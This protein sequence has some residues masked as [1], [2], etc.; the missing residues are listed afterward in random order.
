MADYYPLIARAVTGLDK[1]T[2][3]ARRALYE[4]ARTALVTQLRGVEPALS[5]ADITRERLAL[6]EAIRKVEAEAARRPQQDSAEVPAKV[7]TPPPRFEQPPSSTPSSPPPPPPSEGRSD[8]AFAPPP[9]PDWDELHRE[10]DGNASPQAESVET[11][12]AEAE[13]PEAAPEAPSADEPPLPLETE[14]QPEP[15]PTESASP[16]EAAPS[17]ETPRQEPFVA[18]RRLDKKPRGERTSIVDEGLKGF[19]DVMAET[20]DL[21]GATASASR[22]ARETR[23]A[24]STLPPASDIERIE[25]R[26]DPRFGSEDFKPSEQEVPPP[27]PRRGEPRSGG[28]AR[29][30]PPPRPQ[31]EEFDEPQ[32][33]RLRSGGILRK[34]ISLAV[35]LL[36]VGAAVFAYRE[37]GSDIAGMFQSAQPPV[38]QAS[39][40]APQA[41]PKISDRIGGPQ[42]DTTSRSAPSTT[43]AVAQR[44]VLYEQ[45]ATAQDRKQYVGSV[46]WRTENTSPGPG[47][48]PDLALKAEIEIPERQIRA[49]LTLRRNLDQAL[50]VSHTLEILFSTPADFPPGGIANLIDVG[51][52]EASQTRGAP[53]R[54]TSVKVTN[55]FFL[56]GLIAN[57]IDLRRNILILKEG[58]WMQVRMTYN[59][60]QAGLLV[61]EKGVP[62]DRAVEEVLTAWGQNPPTQQQ[63]QR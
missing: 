43:A 26:M 11:P 20:D 57:E 35:L 53:F 4:R 2:G 23:E 40:E 18:P 3:E 5:E 56:L 1:S 41:R 36:L 30:T 28:R 63:G 42:Q 50:P 7:V 48:P 31:S 9:P 21:G 22:S 46:I 10:L 15:A 6:E 62:G 34:V 19:R 51:M 52:Q 16:P 13:S 25:P 47:Q 32:E 38:T 14:A 17:P 39:R 61:V 12:A 29:P 8:D 44:A 54:G 33:Q 24:F 60:G 49:S 55:G 45:G 37:W 27:P 59:N 58:A